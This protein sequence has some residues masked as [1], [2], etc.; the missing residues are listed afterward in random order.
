MKLPV[1]RALLAGVAVVAAA[2]VFAAGYLV[3]DREETARPAFHDMRV[4]H[5]S[6]L[7]SLVDPD[8]P[9]VRSLAVRLG[10]PEAAYAFVRDRIR[11]EPMAPGLSPREILRAEKGSCLGKATLLCSVYRA[12]GIPARDVRVIVGNIAL[13][14][15][16]VDH[17]W[18]DMEYKGYCFQQDPSSFLG[19]FEFGQ[20]PGMA[21]TRYFVQEEN[22]C[23][24]DEGFAVVSQLN[25]FRMG[26]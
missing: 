23:F 8:D 10:T 21:F 6:D 4:N 14:D 20:F 2:G 9:A 11:Y 19:V 7:V 16:L 22:F 13:P 1:G 12:M 5:V 24:N 25:R 15:R 26:M 3:R 17:A 18:I